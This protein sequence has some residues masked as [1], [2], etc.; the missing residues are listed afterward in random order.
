M[1]LKATVQEAMKPMITS[2][3]AIKVSQAA[4]ATRA[5]PEA[6]P[7]PTTIQEEEEAIQAYSYPEASMDVA[8]AA[9]LPSPTTL[10]KMPKSP[11]TYTPP[12]CVLTSPKTEDKY[13]AKG[14]ATTTVTLVDAHE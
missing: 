11:W 2:R 5:H 14:T 1:A 12:S 8:S 4:V 9:L 10:M 6:T 13:S 7:I 3:A